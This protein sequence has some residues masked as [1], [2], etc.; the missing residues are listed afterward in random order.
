MG[1]GPRNVTDGLDNMD[2]SD[3]LCNMG[4]GLGCNE[5]VGDVLEC[6]DN[7]ADGLNESGDK[8]RKDMGDG[9]DSSDNDYVASGESSDE[10]S[11]S[12]CC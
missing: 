10:E 3:G 12:N 1:D 4:D 5:N 7:M 2:V 8:G 11:I 9:L 6:N